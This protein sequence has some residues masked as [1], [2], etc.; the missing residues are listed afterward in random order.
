VSK[1]IRHKYIL[2]LIKK[3]QRL[4]QLEKLKVYTTKL[5]IKSKRYERKNLKNSLTGDAKS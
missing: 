4:K 5:N 1:I 2:K 3:E